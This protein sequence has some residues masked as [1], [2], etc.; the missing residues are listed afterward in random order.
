MRH[1]KAEQWE[2]RLKQ[3][4]DKVNDYLEKTYGHLYPLHPARPPHRTTASPEADG[5]FDVGGVFSAGFGSRH[6]P[7][8]IVEIRFGTLAHVPDAV[9]IRIEQDAIGQLRKEL[10]LAFPGTRLRVEKDGP[11]YK[12]VGD[13]TLGKA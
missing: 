6:G 11:V 8:Y 1:P 9:R 3:A 7:G 2:S 13:L 10:P 4:F 12:V 5:L